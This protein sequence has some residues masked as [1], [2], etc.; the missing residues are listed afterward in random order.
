MAESEQNGIR[1]KISQIFKKSPDAVINF[2]LIL[3]FIILGIAQIFLAEILSFERFVKVALLI[4]II[5]SSAPILRLISQTESLETLKKEF[6]DLQN[7]IEKS[8]RSFVDGHIDRLSRDELIDFIIR[9]TEKLKKF[10]NVSH[11]IYKLYREHGLLE[12]ANEPQR[13]KLKLIYRNEGEIDSDKIQLTV[14]QN[15]LAINEAKIE[16][17]KNKCLNRDGLVTYIGLDVKEL[18]KNKMQEEIHKLLNT[19]LKFTSSFPING[20][21]YD[22]KE[23][24]LNLIISEDEFKNKKSQRKDD[25][26]KTSEPKSY[27]VY[28]VSKQKDNYYLNLG[29]YFNVEIPPQENIDIHIETKVI[30]PNYYLW[31]YEFVTWTDGIDF[32]LDF[33]DNYETDI[34][35]VLPGASPSINNNK[36]L[37]YNGWIMPHSSISAVWKK[38]NM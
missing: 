16:S 14:I 25:T 27:G 35:Y 4:L 21:K 17:G 19:Y 26:N 33:N 1:K 20:T 32:E 3:I 5:A 2:L 12:L 18:D 36:K 30:V 38:K 9:C 22:N 34:S 8:S 29:I 11:Q 31:T 6:K 13:S 24:T 37:I 10:E 7:I 28:R 23:L 15:Y